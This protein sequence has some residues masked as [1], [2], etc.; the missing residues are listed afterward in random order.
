[1][2][3]TEL[4]QQLKPYFRIQEL[5]CPHCYN[6]FGESAWQFLSTELL[7]T[8]LILRTKV[9]NKPITVNTWHNGG[10]FSQRGLRC[11]ICELV[12]SKDSIYMSQHCLG[13]AI[14]FNAKDMTSEEVNNKIRECADMFE[15]PVRLEANTDGWSHIDCMHILSPFKQLT[16]F[17]G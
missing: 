12:K 3:R 11:N 10:Q 6:K 16:E 5:I 7:S 9:I 14:D 15:Y 13:N 2:N 8:L 1:M 4:I 17:N